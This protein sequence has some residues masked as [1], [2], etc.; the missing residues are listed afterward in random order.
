VQD[1]WSKVF[2]LRG[3]L[4]MPS[5]IAPNGQHTVAKLTG[6][7]A[8]AKPRRVEGKV[9]SFYVGQGTHTVGRLVQNLDFDR[10]T[11]SPEMMALFDG[12]MTMYS[13]QKSAVSY[14]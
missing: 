8:G 1:S 11:G 6:L 13:S 7:R 4:V 9:G 12:A 14:Q 5:A 2:G 10:L 3:G